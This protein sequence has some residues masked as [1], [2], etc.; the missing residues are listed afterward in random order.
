MLAPILA[1]LRPV[2][3]PRLQSVRSRA[4]G[5]GALPPHPH[6]TSPS[7]SHPLGTAQP[8]LATR[9]APTGVRTARPAIAITNPVIATGG[10]AP[11]RP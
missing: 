10:I 1:R 11:C 3:G 6:P 4:R 8:A 5:P 9:L 7:P 2:A